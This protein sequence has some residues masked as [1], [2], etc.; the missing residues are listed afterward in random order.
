M[1]RCVSGWDIGQVC[2]WVGCVGKVCERVGCVDV[3]C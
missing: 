2:E 1:C 3:M